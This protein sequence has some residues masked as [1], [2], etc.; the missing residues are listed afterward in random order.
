M[1]RNET[2]RQDAGGTL[3]RVLLTCVSDGDPAAVTRGE[4]RNT[5]VAGL[6]FPLSPKGARETDVAAIGSRRASDVGQEIP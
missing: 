4:T 6:L 2:R 1:G 3:P 5:N